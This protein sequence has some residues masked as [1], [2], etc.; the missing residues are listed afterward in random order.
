[1][2]GWLTWLRSKDRLFIAAATRDPAIEKKLEELEIRRF[3]KDILKMS[4]KEWRQHFGY[5]TTKNIQLGLFFRTIIWQVYEEIQAGNIPDFMKKKEN[6]RG[7]WYHISSK[8]YDYKDLREDRSGLMGN[9]L[10]T[11]IEAGLMSYKDFDFKD[12]DK[13]QRHIGTENPYIIVLAEK[14]GFES[15]LDE[16]HQIYGCTTIFTAGH[17]SSLSINY[18]V[19]EM[20]EAGIDISQQFTVIAMVDFDPVGWNIARHFVLKI[21]QSGIQKVREFDQYKG[22]YVIQDRKTGE[23]IRSPYHW[24][25]LIKPVNLPPGIKPRDVSRRLKTKEIPEL[26]TGEWA[27]NTGGINGK[28]QRDR[29][30]LADIFQ[31][32]H[33]MELVAQALAPFLDVDPETARRIS[34]V[35]ELEKVMKEFLLYKI[36]NRPDPS[37]PA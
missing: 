5:E 10:Q 23:T 13:D 20:V 2:P 31:R 3:D 26:A 28:G 14:D 30:I 19:A 33:I 6:I 34:Q 7:L 24:L 9:E 1:M 8:L 18:M 29:G 4:R 17:G 27:A 35:R 15:I 21:G 11:L 32:D 37:P 16:V 12:S 36:L 25:D 22:I